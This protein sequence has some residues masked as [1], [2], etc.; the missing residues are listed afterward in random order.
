MS[1]APID[2]LPPYVKSV[3]WDDR[4]TGA[5]DLLIKLVEVGPEG[6]T[7]QQVSA[8]HEAYGDELASYAANILIQ[9][10][11][12]KIEFHD[13]ETKL[14]LIEAEGHP[15]LIQGDIQDRAGGIVKFGE[16]SGAEGIKEAGGY[17]VARRAEGESVGRQQILQGAQ[18]WQ[19]IGSFRIRTIFA[20]SGGG[21]DYTINE[22]GSSLLD[23]G[24]LGDKRDW[25]D[26]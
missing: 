24:Y 23:I 7:M 15:L 19:L 25:R 22:G 14:V 9:R 26:D 16:W 3:L 12:A 8:M 2:T 20:I 4:Y 10:G 6:M 17:Y 1:K 13:P 5:A 18:I 21:F 11:L